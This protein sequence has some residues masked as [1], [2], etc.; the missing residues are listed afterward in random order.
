MLHIYTEQTGNRFEVICNPDEDP[1]S[2]NAFT[3]KTFKDELAA[4]AYKYT[5]ANTMQTANVATN[6]S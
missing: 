2:V 3:L 6:V 4:N 1:D 5:F